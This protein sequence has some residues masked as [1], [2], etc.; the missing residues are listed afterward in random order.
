MKSKRLVAYTNNPIYLQRIKVYSP[1]FK[2][3]IR[4]WFIKVFTN[5]KVG[6]LDLSELNKK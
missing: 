2:N 1:S 4:V 6:I 5:K 3:R